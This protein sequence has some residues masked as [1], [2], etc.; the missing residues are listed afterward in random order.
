MAVDTQPSLRRSLG[1][2]ALIAY[3]VGD[4]LGAGIYALT[5]KVAGMAGYDAWLAFTL[6]LG[7]AALTALTYAEFVARHPHSGGAA[8]FCMQAYRSPAVALLLGWLVLC[9]GIVSMA[10]ASRAVAG[11]LTPVL[12]GLPP[13]VAVLAFLLLLAGITFWGIRESSGANLVCTFV[14]ASGLLLVLCVGLA[15]L[16]A[17]SAPPPAA[18][19]GDVPEASWAMIASAASLAFYAFI[20][21]EDLVNVAEEA[22]EPRKHLPVAIL[23][24]LVLTGVTYVVIS[25]VSTSIVSPAVLKA[26]DAPLLEVVHVAAPGIPRGLFTVIALFAVANTAL[27]NF[28]MVSRLMY[29]MSRHHLLPG[30][31][32][33][34]HPTRRTPHRAVYIALAIAIVLALTGTVEYLAGTTSVLVL[35]V[36][37]FVHAGLILIKRRNSDWNG[38]R[39]PVFVPII[40]IFATILLLI[41]AEGASLRAAFLLLGAGVLLLAWQGLRGELRQVEFEEEL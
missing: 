14:E 18:G 33:S 39:I 8:Y 22:H 35:I 30:F 9:S 29:G 34:V 21:F 38:F 36:F 1:L 41:S 10:A 25:W 37:A 16:G 12:P 6:A 5:G 11:Y 17:G 24:A 20:G 28:V 32:A 23:A 27:L 7:V 31:I 40:G 19:A 26:T 2:F 15:Y 13:N 4:I 3:G